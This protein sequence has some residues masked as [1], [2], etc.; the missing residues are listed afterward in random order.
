MFTFRYHAISLVAVFLALG[1]GVLLGV[2]IGEEGIVSG[3]RAGTSR[4]RCAATS[5]RLAR[6]QRDLRRELEQRATFERQ[7][8]PA[9]VGDLLPDWRI[10]IVAMGGLPSGY[11]VGRS[12]TPSSPPGRTSSR[13]R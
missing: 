1:I 3:A 12:A 10:G 4:S 7:A 13:S 5:T 9:L 2:A 11:I 8:Y 6:R